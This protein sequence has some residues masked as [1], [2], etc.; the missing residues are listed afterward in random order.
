MYGSVQ[1][2]LR[3]PLLYKKGEPIPMKTLETNRLIL[4]AFRE[5]DLEDFYA[6]AS[7]PNVG[8]NAGWKPH[9]DRAESRKIL[10]SFIE[11]DEV[12][13]L[14]DKISGKVMGSIGLH[15]DPVRN[16]PATRMVG[17]AMS[18]DYWGKGLMPEALERVL[19]F[20]FEEA[21]MDIVWVCHYPFNI[22]S[23]RNIEKAG[24]VYE[25]TQ[26]QASVRYDGVVLDKATYSL[27]K[28][29]YEALH[30]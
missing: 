21:G 27:T 30:R 11:E 6:Y 8:P 5:S 22:R 14:V 24:F 12:W 20:A 17:Y 26:R 7:T 16:N 25:G 29:E 10:R 15:K 18:E 3:R 2:D 23:K 13:A 19:R 9:A 1:D 28:E 4:R